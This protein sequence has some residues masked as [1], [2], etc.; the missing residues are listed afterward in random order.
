MHIILAYPRGFCSGV[1]IAIN[2]LESAISRFGLP[3]YVY[4]E[5]VHNSWVVED[6]KSRGVKFV[7]DIDEVPSGSRL[8]FSAHGVA[9]DIRV[10]AAQRD[11]ETIDATCPLVANVHREVIRY[12]AANYKIIL[13]GH[14]GHDEVVGTMNEAPDSIRLIEKEDDIKKLN[15]TPDEKLVILTQTTLSVTETAKIIELLREKFPQNIIE[16]NSNICYATQ[17]RQDAIT[18]LASEADVVLIIGSQ[19]SS[20]SK[21]LYERGKS[22]GI[23]S[24]LIDGPDNIDCNW[25][26]DNDTVLISAGASAPEYVVQNCVQI[27]KKNFNTTIEERRTCKDDALQINNKTLPSD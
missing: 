2:T 25:F 16:S 6:F 24:I 26:N 11:I 4:H 13:I 27:L 7:D 3:L 14:S 8:M 9:P 19:N 10:V 5:I 15:F 17:H 20:N 1:N 22:L 18:K 23:R 21:R 12:A